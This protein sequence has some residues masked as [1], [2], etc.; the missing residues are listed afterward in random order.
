MLEDPRQ[1]HLLH[2]RDFC[3]CPSPLSYFLLHRF[4]HTIIE[5]G[6]K[7]EVAAEEMIS[8][9]QAAS[10]QNNWQLK[11]SRFNSAVLFCS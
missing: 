3:L 2:T 4:L 5:E 6:I 1:K 10:V 7:A 9:M 11:A 8:V